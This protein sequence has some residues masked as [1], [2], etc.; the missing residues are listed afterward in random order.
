MNYAITFDIE[1]RILQS[2]DPEYAPLDAVLVDTLPDGDIH[3]YRYANGAYVYDPLPGPETRPDPV[4]A[5][6]ARITAIEA[7]QVGQ[8]GALNDLVLYIAAE[9]GGF[10]AERGLGGTLPGQGQVV[11]ACTDNL[12][13]PKPG[14]ARPELEIRD[15]RPFQSDAKNATET[16]GSAAG[17]AAAIEGGEPQ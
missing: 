13:Q 2:A 4:A 10:E 6:S 11:R 1:N 7:G 8:A 14:I 9:I 17:R 3:D 15:A 5:L 12:F 16:N